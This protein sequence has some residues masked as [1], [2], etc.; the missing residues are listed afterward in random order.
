MVRFVSRRVVWSL[1][2]LV[3]VASIAFFAVNI[4]L[5]YDFAVGIGRRPAAVLEIREQLGLDRPIWIRWLDYLWHLMRGDLGESYGGQLGDDFGTQRVSSLLW[6]ALPTTV[7]IFAF[8]GIVAYLIGEWFGRRI[9]WSRSRSF[10]AASSTGSVLMFT[11]F[12]PWLVFLLIY[13]GTDRLFQVRSA[14]GLGPKAFSPVPE[15][16]LLIVL[17]GGLLLALA[18]GI[19]LKGWARKR[20]RRVLAVAAVPACIAGFLAVLPLVGVWA[21]AIDILL[22]PSA[23]MAMLALVLIATGENMLVMRAGVSA[24]M[25]EDYVLTARAKGVPERLI[26]DRHV[27]P[28]AV[29]PAITRLITSVPYL[30]AGL[31]I[32]ERELRLD[33]VA[34]LF[35]QAIEAADVPIIVGILVGVGLIGLVLRIVL[36]MVQAQIDPRLRTEGR[37]V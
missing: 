34:N 7:T 36:D 14:F 1:V 23:V 25:P 21:E 10:R 37:A 12:P 8:G 30:I 19:L 32:I 31:I 20:D 6:R 28:N 16:P 15:G 35:F 26:R 5:P 22:W 11:A 17:A 9:A 18:G 24:E 33:G 3:L 4:L 13:F 29:I 2:M 27:A